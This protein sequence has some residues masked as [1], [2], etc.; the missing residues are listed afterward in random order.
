MRACVFV[1]LFLTSAAQGLAPDQPADGQTFSSFFRQITRGGLFQGVKLDAP[2]AYQQAF[3]GRIRRGVWVGEL[4]LERNS[5]IQAGVNFWGEW[6]QTQVP[7]N[8]LAR[9]WPHGA[10][11]FV[12]ELIR[13]SST[14]CTA[15]SSDFA[16]PWEK[17]NRCAREALVR[18]VLFSWLDQQGRS[19]VELLARRYG[20]DS[21]DLTDAAE[22]FFLGEAEFTA[23]IREMGY[24]GQVYFRGIT[25]PNPHDPQK[26]WV[27]LNDD[28]MRKYSSFDRSLLQMME[29]AGIVSHEL[30]HVAQEVLGRKLGVSVDIESAEEALLIEGQAENESELAWLSFAPQA[31]APTPFA[32]FAREQAVEVLF[33]EGNESSG[34]L[35][36]YTVGLPFASALNSI[37][38]DQKQDPVDL[39]RQ[40]EL[41]LGDQMTLETWLFAKFPSD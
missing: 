1:I 19:L 31:I 9:A 40:I 20:L 28:L 22:I 32:L 29:Y 34:N 21:K 24:G 14:G 11:A 26:I 16:K 13:H 39:N 30:S 6:F 38:R 41:V 37:W 23:K 18:T 35:F 27:V 7:Q 8:I 15:N 10:D 5:L 2:S 17:W 25:G 4:D 3:Y 33:R 12:A 36:P